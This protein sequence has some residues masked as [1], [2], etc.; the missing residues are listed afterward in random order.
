MATKAVTKTASMDTKEFYEALQKVNTVKPKSPSPILMPLS[1]NI[2]AEFA[3]N[4]ATLIS[5]DM[6]S[7]IRITID[8]ENNG[9]FSALL[10]RNT[11]AKFLHG[12]NSKTIVT[13]DSDNQITLSREGIGDLSL[14]TPKIT[15]FPPIPKIPDNL[16]WQTLDGK[17]FCSMLPII[18]IAC[19]IKE[20][21]PILK[22]IACNDGAIAAADGFRLHILKDNRLN[23]GLGDKQV[24]IPL[25]SVNLISKLFRKE[26]QIQM[27]LETKTDTQGLEVKEVIKYIHFKSEGISLTTIPILGNYPNYEQLIP[28]TFNCK[29]TFSAPLMLQRLS[30]IDAE[31]ISGG[32]TRF[33]FGTSE[34]GEQMCSLSAKTED[35]VDYHLT[36]PAKYEPTEGKIAF[37]Y[38]YVLDAIKPFS[39]CNLEL[40][41]L[42]SPGKFTGDIEG[43][44]IVVMPMSVPWD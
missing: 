6:E 39:V 29:A 44:T 27:A 18:S 19:A 40:T 2:L 22:G 16:Q 34:H 35:D 20:G 42:A 3:N 26:S 10:P 5:T 7:V 13:Q 1:K 4:K 9:D 24:V 21:R 37:N 8:C 32:I 31:S 43:L 33:V 25:K 36:C 41:G 38:K 11:T 17:W 23:F 30:M 15:D 14:T 28:K 12:G